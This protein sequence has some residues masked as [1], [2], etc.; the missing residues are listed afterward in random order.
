[1]IPVLVS[2]CAERAD[3][4]IFT[5]AVDGAFEA[6]LTGGEIFFE[7]FLPSPG[8]SGS[9]HLWIQRQGPGGTM[10]VIDLLMPPALA[11]GRYD[12]ESP[13]VIEPGSPSNRPH[14]TTAV[15][16]VTTGEE[17]PI[18]HRDVFGTLEV[19]NAGEEISGSF[20]F[21]AYEAVSGPGGGVIAGDRLV[22]VE[23]TF[24]GIPLTV[25]P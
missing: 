2:G 20:Q 5:A 1:V 22:D 9:S 7:E 17:S 13:L 18:F 3:A 15:L 16:Y 21:T 23:G 24:E 14:L 10:L 8:S 11:T 6:N 12:L 25:L 4:P 19:T